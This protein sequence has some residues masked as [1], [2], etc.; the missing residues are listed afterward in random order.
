MVIFS[1]R[2]LPLGIILLMSVG[3]ILSIIFPLL[4]IRWID[5]AQSHD[6]WS[7][8]FEKIDHERRQ[9]ALP[10]PPICCPTCQQYTREEDQCEWCHTHWNPKQLQQR[11]KERWLFLDGTPEP[12]KQAILNKYGH[13]YQ[14]NTKKE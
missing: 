8:T 7:S 11:I 4:G 14:K 3:F 12:E 1:N 9:Q 10:N 5:Q 6:Q 2:I 13:L